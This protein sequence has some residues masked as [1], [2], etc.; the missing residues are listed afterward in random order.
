ML[1]QFFHFKR[2]SPQGILV[3]SKH[4]N[5]NIRFYWSSLLK[6]FNF[7]SGIWKILKLG[8]EFLNQFSFFNGACVFIH[9]YKN[10]GKIRFNI[11]LMYVVINLRISLSNIGC[12]VNNL[13]VIF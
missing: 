13:F 10:L 3:F 6:I 2:K 11:L 1:Q 5:H 7:N 12:I 9:L 8:T 4:S